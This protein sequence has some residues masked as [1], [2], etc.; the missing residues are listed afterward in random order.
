MLVSC[1]L[2]ELGRQA[3]N[4]PYVDRVHEGTADPRIFEILGYPGA[5]ISYSKSWYFDQ[6]PDHEVFFNA[7]VFNE[8]GER[9]WGGDLDLTRSRDDLREVA[10][11]VGP[12]VVTTE[13]PYVLDG[14]PNGFT[15]VGGPEQP[16]SY[17]DIVVIEPSQR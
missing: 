14:L 9:I 4:K 6:Y 17:N 11:L 7:Q 12:I 10:D 2:A 13:W 1:V 5:L 8:Q 16:G 3:V 15:L